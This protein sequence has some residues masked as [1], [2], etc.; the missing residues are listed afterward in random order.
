[1]SR[2]ILLPLGA[3]IIG[4]VCDLIQASEAPPRKILVIF[5]SRRPKIMLAREL[6]GRRGRAME[7]PRCFSIGD[8]V[9]R[10]A[11]ELGYER[12]MLDPADGAALIHQ[13]HPERRLP[14]GGRELSLE[15][16]LSWG[17]TLFSDF[18]ELRSEEVA[19]KALEAVK[20]LAQEPLPASF[21]AQLGHLGEWYQGFC[22]EL[23]AKG[24]STPAST[25]S[26]VAERADRINL[27]GYAQV[28]AAGFYA[29][30]RSEQRILEALLG[31]KNATLILRDGPGIER[32]IKQLGI[33]P[34]RT[35]AV[36]PSPR[37][38]HLRAADS[39]GQVMALGRQVGPGPGLSDTVLVLAKQDTVFPAMHHLLPRLGEDWNISMGYPL[40]RTPL[41]SLLE[42]LAAA[43]EGR[44][45]GAY[46]LPQYLRLMLHPYVKNLSLGGA[47]YPTR[48]LLHAVE[49]ALNRKSRRMVRPG[50]IASDPEVRLEADRRLAG[51]AVQGAGLDQ[52]YRHLG[53]LH[54]LVIGPFEEIDSVADFARKAAAVVSAAAE[55]GT[56]GR[57]PFAERFFYRMAGV[58]EQ[59]E[60]SLMARQRFG[61]VRTYFGLLRHFAAQA[62]VPFPGTPLR[63]LQVL[64][65]METRNLTFRRVVMLDANEGQL[66]AADS[67]DTI[68]PQALRAELGLPTSADREITDR[69]HFQN[70]VAGS[71]EATLC[72]SQGCGSQRSRFLE[73]LSWEEE[74]AGG[75]LQKGAGRLAH[76]TASFSQDDPTPIDKTREMMEAISGLRY[77]ATMLD[78]YLHC[79]LRFCHRYLMRITEKDQ[80]MADVD[81]GDIG[82]VVHDS[83]KRFFGRRLKAAFSYH[84][85]MDREIGE[86]VEQAF[87]DSYGLNQ[88]GNVHLIKSQVK[89]RLTQL[90]GYHASSLPD[91]S[92]ESVELE[93]SPTVETPGAGL[94]PAYG[95]L[96][97][98]DRRGD[99]TVI[100]DYKTGYGETPS[101]ERFLA[102]GRSGWAHWLRSVQLPFYVMLYLAHHPG[103]SADSVNSELLKLGGGGFERRPL[104][105][106]GIDR[107]E[108]YRAYSEAIGV[109]IGEIRDPGLPFAGARDPLRECPGCPY[110]L[111]CGRQWA[112]SGHR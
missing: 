61:S 15:A 6:A 2:S 91:F 20:A 78:C 60:T 111:M 7:A 26:Y 18:E 110:Q 54:D 93:L 96:D 36:R 81:S 32:I 53:R 94:V 56:A 64:G 75:K 107:A 57:H 50:Q 87:Q 63:G 67:V 79:G 29:V 103:T 3:D 62:S 104:F 97:R 69:Y 47:S 8:W 12:A 73:Q 45:D 80:V 101:F 70:L 83:L 68:L 65:F 82:G 21:G 40:S 86:A 100:V 95:I 44:L 23:E 109:L 11:G 5:P 42:A 35:G 52:M 33:S 17:F 31:H 84:K 99:Q 39:H 4:A 106:D 37:I 85:G 92:V 112:G 14:G 13:L 59:L 55:H 77:S 98:V 108:R 105:P 88:D 43:H 51:A 34:R 19:P 58:L 27:S 76:F 74:K 102:E 30:T 24:L 72:Y 9:E 28:I 89:T 16:F 49:E 90:L 41:W 66:P 46:F 25:I 1:M 10:C 38:E 71:E 48:I 22:H